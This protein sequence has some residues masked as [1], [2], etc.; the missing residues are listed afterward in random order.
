APALGE[1]LLTASALLDDSPLDVPV[2]RGVYRPENYDNR[3]HGLV[4]LRN[5]LASS[6]NVP[7]VRTLLLVGPETF[8]EKLQMLGFTGLSTGDYY[9]PSLALGSADV[10]LWELVNGYR[11]L[12]NGGLYSPLS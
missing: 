1:K 5:A 11:T 3:F 6:L 10:S 2:P 8:V 7:A 12:A 9:G 4:P